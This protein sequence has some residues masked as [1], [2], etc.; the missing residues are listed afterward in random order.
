M[1]CD[2]QTL[3]MLHF[4]GN[5]TDSS[6]AGHTWTAG[7][8]GPSGTSATQSKFGGESCFFDGS[9]DY[10]TSADSTDWDLSGDFTVECFYLMSTTT[11]DRCIVSRNTNQFFLAFTGGNAVWASINGVQSS[12]FSVTLDTT[13]WH[14]L[15][16][17]RSGST[18]TI[19]VDGASVGTWSDSGAINEASA[20][21]I[22]RR[23]NATWYFHGYIDE[24]RFSNGVARYTGAFTPTTSAFCGSTDTSGMFLVF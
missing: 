12:T 21:E 16:W 13:T 18:N 10:L 5:F 7:A 14:H 9:D 8:S 11:G 15:A 3:T 4:D 23:S 24:F 6:T 20:L 22:G 1:A 17:T 19:W 2:A